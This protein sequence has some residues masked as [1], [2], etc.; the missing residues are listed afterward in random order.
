MWRAGSLTTSRRCSESATP[1]GSRRSWTVSPRSR[2]AASS[3][4]ASVV[5]PAPSRPSIVIKRPVMSYPLRHP[6]AVLMWTSALRAP[7]LSNPMPA[8]P[9][10]EDHPHAAAVL[11]AALPPDG[12]PSHAY[13][14]GGPAGSGKREVARRFAAALLADGAPDPANAAARVESGA[15]PDLTWVAPSSSAGILVGDIDEPVVAAAART[16]FEASRRVFV[17]ER[18]DELNDQAANRMLKTLEEP[19]A[20]AHLLLL[21]SR[22]SKVSPPMSS[23]CQPVRFDAPSA[24]EIGERLERH[25]IAPDTAR[26]CGRLALGDAER[27]LALA[28]A[29]GPARRAGAEALA[30]GAIA[31][32]LADRPWSALLDV[33]KARGETAAG[34]VR[35]AVVEQLDYLPTKERK[36]AER[37]GDE[38]ARRGHRRA[39]SLALDQG[40]SLTGLWLRAVACVPPGA[41][42]LAPHSDRLDALQEDA[43][44]A[45]VHRLRG[46]I[47]LVD[48][49]RISREVNPTEELALE[50]LAY[51]LAAKLRGD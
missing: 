9:G 46:A 27:A 16:P 18:A 38:Q 5:L 24:E 49:V 39:H 20:F 40:L 33:A 45:D 25:G 22:P 44:E 37:E 50:A 6:A 12:T 2:N 32:R 29:D 31:D 17:I 7:I 48:D 34:Q 51:R 1:P 43:A 21:T 14:F 41:P 10:T 4:A 30:R 47:G 23:R 13:L 42:E 8:L 26:A 15:H 19:P 28:L 11:G 35:D 3:P 36:R